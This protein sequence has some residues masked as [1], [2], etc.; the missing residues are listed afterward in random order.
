MDPQALE[1][2]RR[3][4]YV[5]LTRARQRLALLSARERYTFGS[6]SA[7]P[8]SRFLSEIPAEYQEIVE[9]EVIRFGE[10]KVKKAFT[11]GI[12]AGSF[13]R[14]LRTRGKNDISLFGI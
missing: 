13:L 3:L 11:G 6:Y 14:D 7:N 2:E 8:P 12:E 10:P 5:A 4:M 9:A 1:E